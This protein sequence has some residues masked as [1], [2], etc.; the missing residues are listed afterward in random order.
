MKVEVHENLIFVTISQSNTIDIQR[1]DFLVK[2][3]SDEVAE[4]SKASACH[5]GDCWFDPRPSHFAKNSE[6]FM[7]FEVY[8]QSDSDCKLAGVPK[9]FKSRLVTDLTHFW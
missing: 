9:E 6:F 7:I 3:P 8:L 1:L 2:L 5:A 4:W